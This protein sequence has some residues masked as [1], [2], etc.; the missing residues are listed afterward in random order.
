M[1]RQILPGIL[2]LACLSVAPEAEAGHESP[3]YPSFY[4][5]EIRI[6]T[7]APDSVATLLHKNSLHA[8]IG[9]DPFAGGPIPANVKSVESLG[10]YVVVTFN[11][12]SA[13]VKTAPNRC[14]MGRRI[15]EGLAGVKDAFVFH[16]YPVTP[17]HADYLQHFDLARAWEKPAPDVPP[18]GPG[19]G[20]PALQVKARGKLADGLG[21]SRWPV[22]D[23]GEDATVEEVD[24]AT[25]L[26]PRVVSLN[27]WL[28]PPWLKEGWFQA[29]LLLEGAIQDPTRKGRINAIYQRLTTGA[30]D[31]GVEQLNLERTLVSL[32]TQGCE[33]IVVG[34]ALKRAYF[35][36][37]YSEGV[38]NVAFDSQAGLVAPIF[39]RTVKLK[40]FPWNGWLRVGVAAKPASA[41]NPIG[42]FTD[43]FGRLIWFAVGDPAMFPAPSNASWTPDRVA[44]TVT[45]RASATDA[46]G[47]PPDALLPEP[48]TGIL[49]EVGPGKIARTKIVY[50]VLTSSFHDGTPMT[51]ADALYPFIFAYHW[52]MKSAQ[53]GQ[54][55]DPFIHEATALLRE[56]LAGLKVLRI[57]HEVKN[58]ADVK[59]EWRVPVIEAYLKS[60]PMDPQQAASV[61]P[62]WSSL[63]WP[64]LVLMEEAVNRGLAAFSQE[65]AS[66][67]GLSWLDLVRDRDLQ[68]RLAALA[69]AFERERYVPPALKGFVGPEEAEHRWAALR[70]F[71]RKHHHWL[72]ANGP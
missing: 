51:V 27:G 12:G 3:Y 59:L 37:D 72:I 54:P 56:R 68:T 38:E 26:A 50:K 25:L 70:Q 35:N 1:G 32:L 10:S 30:Y 66:R 69:E 14:A 44:A 15:L 62:P 36:T 34:Y 18:K 19:S 7:V 17:Y 60:A 58:L 11:P 24:V 28:G 20:G 46:V 6:E 65:E 52:G 63:P 47:V 13:S 48:G 22:V 31:S 64:L 39:L 53:N 57:E 8:Y 42:G 23:T 5:Q 29:Y 61:A 16:P 9:S 33:R 21:R 41:W 49:R 40:D 55:S 71:Y 2:L 67:R 4:P 43:S 45:P